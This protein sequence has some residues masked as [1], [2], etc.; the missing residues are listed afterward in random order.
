MW[1]FWCFIYPCSTNTT[2]DADFRN[3]TPLWV[4][5]LCH[6][7][8]TSALM[9]LFLCIVHLFIINT[10]RD[11]DWGNLTPL[12]VTGWCH[13]T[14]YVIDV[15]RRLFWCIIHRCSIN[16]TRDTNV[17]NMTLV[18]VTD[19]CHVTISDNVMS[20]DCFGKFHRNLCTRTPK[21]GNSSSAGEKTIILPILKIGFHVALRNVLR[22]FLDIFPIARK[23][24]SKFGRVKKITIRIGIF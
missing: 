16:T 7:N 14:P 6:M 9:Q 19:Q 15:R 20:T 4:I 24:K 13:M 18:W 17:C 23:S 5:R 1:S 2:T 22:Y 21:T 10:A 3:L 11:T 12:W 8:V